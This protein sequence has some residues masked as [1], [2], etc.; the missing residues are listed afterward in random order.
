MTTQLE[1]QARQLGEATRAQAQ[2]AAAAA[3]AEAEA[4]EAAGL[5]CQLTASISCELATMQ[6][7]LEASPNP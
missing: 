3:R 4:A 2:A 6:S 5:Q 1:Q 7:R